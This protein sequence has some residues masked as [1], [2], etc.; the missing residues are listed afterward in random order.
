[1]AGGT[2]TAQNKVR[3]GIY[4]NFSSKGGRVPALG[5][6][7]TAAACRPLSWG[8]VGEVMIIDAG[9]DPTAYVGY[10]TAA[11]QAW[12]L[13]E[14]FKG[15]DV[16]AAPTKLLLYRP[17]A[18]GAVQAAA[19]LS[20]GVTA[21]ALYPG[22]RGN[23]IAVAV[24]E[25]VD[26][27]GTFTVL[28]LVDGAQ[29]D[30]Q[31]AKTVSD[32]KANGWVSFSGDG[33]LAAAAG[34]KLSGGGDGTVEIS[35]YAAALEALESYSF[36]I[37]LYDGADSAVRQAC[38]SFVQRLAGQEGRYSQLVTSGAVNADS[39]FVINSRSGVVLED[40]SVLTAQEAVW[41]LAGAQAGA[42]AYQSL[43]CAA[44]PGAVDVSPKLTGSQI[45]AAI[46]A[47]DVVFSEEFGRVRVETDINTL[48]TFTPELG[49][50]FHKNRTM[51]SCNCLANDIY[52]EFSLH[53]QGKVDNNEEGRGLFKAAILEY[54]LDMYA[55]GG[56]R[57]RPA[58]EDVEVLEG[59]TADSLVINL[60]F[61]LADAVEKIY[62]TVSVS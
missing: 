20:A 41:W 31:Q 34:V 57:Q 4:I 30:R 1:M 13:R 55:R 11:P 24:S 15:T 28:T 22:V 61:R 29:A 2:W 52:R 49:E 42:Q 37:L 5:S 10:D 25:D 60:A 14:F 38:A 58:G 12:F 16:S 43:S 47:G 26:E 44:Y 62:M 59:K 7:G 8:P 17:A 54:L 40:G 3:P 27:P 6:R 53:Y 21:T 35:G 46:L 18:S 39:Q 33:P 36:D 19:E 48:V 50:A 56:L 9:A 32:L 51:R 23:D 45:E